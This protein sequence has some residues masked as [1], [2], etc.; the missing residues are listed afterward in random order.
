MT[1]RDVIE[2][3]ADKSDIADANDQ[4]M[5]AIAID[6]VEIV[7]GMD[8][9]GS[10][11]VVANG[12]NTSVNKQDVDVD[13][14]VIQ[15]NEDNVANV[16]NVV[17]G[18][19]EVTEATDTTVTTGTNATITEKEK[20]TGTEQ[21]RIL[22]QGQAVDDVED[23]E[24]VTNEISETNK[25][26]RHIKKKKHKKQKMMENNDD[27]EDESSDEDAKI[28]DFMNQ[29]KV[30]KSKKFL[31]RKYNQD[32]LKNRKQK[33]HRRRRNKNQTEQF[34]T[35]NQINKERASRNNSPK[36]GAQSSG[37]NNETNES[38][39]NKKQTVNNDDNNDDD[40]IVNID[41]I[42]DDELMGLLGGE[43]G[44]LLAFDSGDDNDDGDDVE[45]GGNEEKE[46]KTDR[47]NE[48]GLMGRIGDGNL[49][50]NGNKGKNKNNDELELIDVSSVWS[51]FGS[52][53]EIVYFDNENDDD[54]SHSTSLVDSGIIFLGLARIYCGTINE[55]SIIHIFDAKSNHYMIKGFKIFHLMGQNLQHIKSVPC[56]NICGIGGIEDYLI[57][58][59]FVCKG[60]NYCAKI[61]RI[62]KM[63]FP[64][65]RVAIASHKYKE[66]K[67]LEQGLKYLNT[68][69]NGVE[70]MLAETGEYVIC[71]NGE[72]HLTRCIR[73]LKDTFAKNIALNVSK[74]IVSFKET[75]VNVSNEELK[76][77]FD[78]FGENGL[79]T[80][81]GNRPC[82]LQ[83]TKTTPNGKCIF[84]VQAV[85]MSK[86]LIEFVETNQMRI[87][88]LLDFLS[89]AIENKSKYQRGKNKQEKMELLR[90]EFNQ[91]KNFMNELQ[92]IFEKLKKK[93]KKSKKSKKNKKNKNK[94]KEK[95]SEADSS[96][97]KKEINGNNKDSKDNKD[98]KNSD[99]RKDNRKDN[100][101][102]KITTEEKTNNNN[103]NSNESDKKKK[104]TTIAR[105]GVEHFVYLSAFGP[106]MVGSNM[107]FICDQLLQSH[108]SLLSRLNWIETQ[109]F[110][111]D[112]DNDNK[113]K[114]SN[115]GND[116]SKSNEINGM[117][118]NDS[119]YGIIAQSINSGFQ[120][121]CNN[122]PLCHEPMYGVAFIV[123]DIV[124]SEWDS[125]TSNMTD[126]HGPI[127][128]QVMAT[129][130][131]AFYEAFLGQSPRLVEPM[132]KMFIQGT[133]DVLGGIYDVIA[134]KK[135]TI[136]NETSVQGT[137]LFDIDA[138]LPVIQSFGFS[139]Q[140]RTETGG[141]VVPQ[142]VF[143]HWQILDM[144]PL[145]MP[146][147]KDEIDLHGSESKQ[148][149][150]SK[151]LIDNVRERKGLQIDKMEVEF[152]EKQS[153]LSKKK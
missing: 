39:H 148:E 26:S 38:N 52:N 29:F 100:N 87:T 152:A 80:V 123:T 143:S 2:V 25:Q 102:T 66:M 32:A 115:S 99:N 97:A 43:D 125:T 133:S 54:N 79:N 41:D 73:D 12:N 114:N 139:K 101:D 117:N 23:V 126:I 150:Y 105:L 145:W 135:G 141:N 110:G 64:I 92:H 48:L 153:T 61:K 142:L 106:R 6:D 76:A 111:S 33:L 86:K 34:D 75:I 140:L 10:T 4:V 14:D 24:D 68:S 132:Y 59:G 35:L 151:T 30:N 144:D 118:V 57:K 28:R 69:D 56:G 109:I 122:G 134:M 18:T 67:Q 78:F 146:M 42:D 131:K 90:K 121:V 9:I 53:A 31:H 11:D 130:K 138:M 103:N 58:S 128:G 40:D 1:G 8:D 82:K 129:L 63:S 72:L 21:V 16:V 147:T 65:V 94:H 51:Q 5:Q 98:S 93:S 49:Q 13:V 149:I 19:D 3:V 108:S 88:N 62:S 47:N 27:E 50:F 60:I 96:L 116:E 83:V 77:R 45:N 36:I 15:S 81:Y 44:E 37:N 85:P 127:S 46:Q 137:N 55:S 119:F 74:P 95:G 70:I 107:L 20:E 89:H 22:Q 91:H 104:D 136:L 113:D 71:A 124:C 7:N 84:T 112:N 120:L 17:N